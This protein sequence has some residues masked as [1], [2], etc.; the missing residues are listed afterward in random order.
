MG[1][2]FDFATFCE[3]LFVISGFC[4][5]HYIEQ[6][7][8]QQQYITTLLK[9]YI[10]ILGPAVVPC[11][12]YSF[13]MI[14]YRII[15]GSWFYNESFSITNLLASLAGVQFAWLIPPGERTNVILG[16]NPPTWYID[17]LLLSFVIL[18]I[19]VWLS[20]RTRIN[21]VWFL[22][23]TVLI[24]AYSY[25]SGLDFPFFNWAACRGYYAFFTGIL[26]ALYDKAIVNFRF[27]KV[28]RYATICIL[29]LA[30]IIIYRYGFVR[31]FGL[32][33]GIFPAV[34]LLC[35]TDNLKKIFSHKIWQFL[36]C[37]SYDVY[38]WHFAFILF[39]I[40]LRDKGF[41]NYTFASSSY[42]CLLLFT[43]FI[44]AVSTLAYTVIEKRIIQN[45]LQAILQMFIIN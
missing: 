39:F 32:T 22:I 29:A 37:V 43:I 36:G 8:C 10:R 2:G 18:T 20:D 30:G 28:L 19:L 6:M 41:I 12:F 21:V 31:A 7:N 4:S 26:L 23:L 14:V 9:R 27:E 34:I 16:I 42:V 24:G 1:G 38:L 45:K 13:A 35:V 3:L 44:W 15:E 25:Q 33:F 5:L 11:F 17:S 40:I